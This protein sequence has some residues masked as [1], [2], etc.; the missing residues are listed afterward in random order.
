MTKSFE[1][2]HGTPIQGMW[3]KWMNT[4]PSGVAGPTLDSTVL[5]LEIT[6]NLYNMKLSTETVTRDGTNLGYNNPATV[7]LVP[8]PDFSATTVPGVSAAKTLH[9]YVMWLN[10]HITLES[11]Q[12]AAKDA[13]ASAVTW[14]GI[15][16]PLE[17]IATK[18]CHSA[19]L[20]TQCTT[21]GN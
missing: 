4:P 12:D 3:I 8:V 9:A 11:T 10:P 14:D 2:F 21:G 18:T 19:T 6:F 1:S 15:Y 17:F 16:L 13:V 20:A 7:G 5:D